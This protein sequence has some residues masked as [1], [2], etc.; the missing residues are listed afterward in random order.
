[1]TKEDD[2]VNRLLKQAHSQL[3]Q[4]K[5]AVDKLS[6]SNDLKKAL[7]FVLKWE[8]EYSNDPADPGGETKW[9]ISKRAYP[10]EDIKNLSRERALEIYANDYWFAAGCD[11]IPFPYNVAVFDTAVNCGVSRATSW[12]KQAGN[13]D[14]FLDKRKQH[15]IN[16]V[17]TNE[18]L[19][20]F[21][22]GWWARLADLRKFVEINKTIGDGCPG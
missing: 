8:G 13:V 2:E 12:H 19:V 9:G 20:R 17:N 11:S 10:K 5:E 6:R 14:Q 21:A 7:T 18:N 22:R 15:Y 1:M 4:A 3:R 16:L